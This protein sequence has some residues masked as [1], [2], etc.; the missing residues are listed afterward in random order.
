VYQRIERD[1]P[2]LLYVAAA[3]LAVSAKPKVDVIIG[4]IQTA[5][6]AAG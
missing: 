1:A 6:A 2:Q 3:A 5:E 4:V